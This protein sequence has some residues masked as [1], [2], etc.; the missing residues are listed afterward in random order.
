MNITV[1]NFAPDDAVLIIQ[2]HEKDQ[3]LLGIC[4][5]RNPDGTVYVRV[6]DVQN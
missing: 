2:A 1:K 5:Y 3:E 6:R 4:V